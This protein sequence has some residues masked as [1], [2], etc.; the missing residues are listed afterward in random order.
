MQRY[1]TLCGR[2]TAL[3]MVEK[4]GFLGIIRSEIVGRYRQIRKRKKETEM[5]VNYH[6]HTERCGHARGSERAYIETAIA[7]GL[8]TIGFSDHAPMPFP[9]GH[10]SGYRMT[11]EELPGYVETLLALREEYRGRIEIL[12]GLEAEYYPHVF[13]AFLALLA[14]YPID[15]LIL[16]QHFLRDETGAPYP[17]HPTSDESVLREYTDQVIAGMRTGAF[18]YVAHPDVMNFTGSDEIYLPYARRLV[19]AAKELGLPLEYNL[20]GQ[21][22]GRQYPRKSFFA[23]AAAEGADV[24]IASDAHDPERVAEPGELRK[25]AAFLSE[26]GVHPLTRIRLRPVP[27]H[28]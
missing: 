13:G 18:S 23:V 15:Y 22:D 7:R 27:K 12:I 14:P 4:N 25:A 19:R 1:A 16:G 6:T 20:L 11:P 9:D 5:L 21:A 2:Q 3:S 10:V 17:G 26:L 24:I 8:E 28:L